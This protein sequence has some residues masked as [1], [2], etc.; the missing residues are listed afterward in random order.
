[1]ASRVPQRP[2]Q[3][4]RSQSE[5]T[6][7][8]GDNSQHREEEER[9]QLISFIAK[10]T[11][12]LAERDVAQV[13]FDNAKKAHNRI[14]SLAKAA[15]PIFTR[16]YLEKKMEEMNRSPS[17]NAEAKAMESRHDRWLGILTP[18]QQK[19]FTEPGTPQEARDEYD[20]EARGYSMGLRGQGPTL[21][22][23]IPPRMD[24]PF[25]KGHGVGYAEYRKALEANV[26]GK[27]RLAQ[28]AEADYAE[29]NPEVDVEAAARR[30]KGSGF[31][32]TDATDESLDEPFEA[33]EA[34]LAAQVTRP[35]RSEPEVV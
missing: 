32:V 34:E 8:I 2:R 15:N 14:F 28:Q 30:L 19:M 17:E 5:A 4:P 16:K 10:A 22:E 6:A 26:P 35:D 25:L 12:T 18:E 20:W 24:Q 29:D 9:V 13:P 21:P 11:Q 7:T 3:A 1:M 33:S 23:G 31:M 27:P